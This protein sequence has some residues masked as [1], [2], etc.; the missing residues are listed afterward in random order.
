MTPDTRDAVVDFVNKWSEKTGI[1]VYRWT[2][3]LGI[4]RAK[5]YAWVERYGCANEHN[6]KVPRDHWLEDWEREA[7]VEFFDRN[8]LNGYR[9]LTF[10]MMDADVVF[11]SPATVYRVLKAAGRLDRLPQE[12]S[13]KGTGFVQ[14]DAPH[15]HWHVDISYI[16]IANTFY[17]L[18]SVLDGYS[19]LIVHWEIREAMTTKDVETV[20]QRG[21]ERFPQASPRII[22][23]NGPQFVAKDFKTF[24]RVTGMTHVRTSLYYPQSNGKL[25]A[26]NKTIKKGTVRLRSPQGLEDARQMVAEFVDEYNNRRLHSS[27]GYVTPADKLAGRDKAIWSRRDEKLENARKF[28]A[29]RRR[30]ARAA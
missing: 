8:P 14:P 26:L 16:N 15:M 27:I 10:M 5:F 22:S 19:R 17:Y 20:I 6:A 29:S 1:P 3:W 24:I 28:R 4:H 7:L 9:R 30:E 23:D 2:R 13:K 18:C 12:P 25:E 21:R 11:A